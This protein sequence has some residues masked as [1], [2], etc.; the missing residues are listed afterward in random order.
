MCMAAAKGTRRQGRLGGY[1]RKTPGGD[2]DG[3]ETA[4]EVRALAGVH[5]ERPN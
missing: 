4:T 5:V 3:T 1:T 2:S